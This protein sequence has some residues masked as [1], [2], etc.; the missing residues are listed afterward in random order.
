M[1]KKP[2][3]EES[4]LNISLPM[5]IQAVGFISA[6]VWGY[7]QLNTR[8]S[9]VEHQAQANQT[10]IE[11][12][13]AMQDLPIPSDVRQ[14]EK[15]NRIEEEIR[16]A[17]FEAKKSGSKNSYE[18]TPESFALS[19]EFASNKGKLPWPLEKG[20]ITGN[21]GSQKHLVF[22]GV[23]TFNNGVDIAT[24]EG[25]D[26]RV[27]FDGTVSRIFFIKGE[28]K[29]ILISHG[30]YFSVYSG[31]KEVTVS[32]GDKLLAKEKIGSVLTHDDEKKTELHFEIWN[33][34]DKQ[35]PSKWLYNAD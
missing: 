16:R 10:A 13:K 30:D 29:A 14:D 26:V 5:L 32:T 9:F 35:N 17:R 3:G 24:E 7:G 31:L 27:V 34:Y 23:E 12:M 19:S 22:S 20:V 11:E 8:I 28:G 6:M 2:I 1:N 25:A 21:Y 33:G 18:L 4:S 15:L